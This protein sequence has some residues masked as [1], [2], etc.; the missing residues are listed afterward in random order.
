MIA[1]YLRALLGETDEELLCDYELTSLSMYAGGVGEGI[2]GEGFRSRNNSY[3]RETLEHLKTYSDAP[4]LGGRLRDFLRV[5][6][7][8]E[9]TLSRVAEILRA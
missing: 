7:I 8:P 2:E 9:E 4:T 3:V 1:M 6:K 5:C